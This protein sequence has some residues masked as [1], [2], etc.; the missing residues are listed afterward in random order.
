[1]KINKTIIKIVGMIECPTDFVNKLTNDGYRLQEKI[2]SNEDREKSAK[3]YKNTFYPEVRK[4]LFLDNDSSSIIKIYQ[5]ENSESLIFYKR[6]KTYKVNL[7]RSEVYI[8]PEKTNNESLGMFSLQMEC[9]NEVTDSDVAD[10]NFLVR[11]FN[12]KMKVDQQEKTLDW[13][14]WIENNILIG[15]KIH[16]EQVTVDDYSGSKFKVFTVIDIKQSHS[17]LERCLMLY[18]IGT[19]S[20]I[21]SANGEGPVP[22]SKSYYNKIM[23]DTISVFDNWEALALF[24]SYTIIGSNLLTSP[25]AEKSF[26]DTYFRI[27][28]LNLYVKFNLFRFKAELHLSPLKVRRQFEKFINT[29]NVSQISFNFLPNLIYHAQRKALLIDNELE[30]FNER[31]NRISKGIQEQQQKRTNA[32]L[33]LVTIVASAGSVMPIYNNLEKLKLFLQWPTN[34]FYLIIGV[35]ALTIGFFLFRY[36]FSDSYRSLSRK[37]KKFKS[38]GK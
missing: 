1:M 30:K 31:I 27:Y 36:I 6:D 21:G 28:I 17:H 33:S 9:E 25:M 13:I 2:L 22:P 23:N 3:F 19:G 37:V 26:T 20:P 38:G 4:L 11:S 14:N 18:D 5:K 29:Y 24:D 16:G 12:S 32:L 8:F 34:L 10:V 15:V 35:L 7:K